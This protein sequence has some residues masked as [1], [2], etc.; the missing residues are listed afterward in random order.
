MQYQFTDCQI[1]CDVTDDLLLGE[2][3]RACAAAKRSLT[4][5]AFKFSLAALCSLSPQNVQP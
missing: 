1:Q 2:A 3:F 4:E 5:V